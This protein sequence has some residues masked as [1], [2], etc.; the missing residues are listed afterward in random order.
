MEAIEFKSKI[1]KESIKIP[2][3]VKSQLIKSDNKNVRVIVLLDNSD[4]TEEK[5]YQNFVSEEFLKGYADSDSIY[6]NE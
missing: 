5:V 2:E 4:I 1:D 3:H 6:D